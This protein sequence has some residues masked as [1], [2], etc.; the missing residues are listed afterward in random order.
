M[1]HYY[2]WVRDKPDPRD[3]DHTPTDKE[4]AVYLPQ[5]FSL[6]SLMPAVYD[7]GE[8]GSCTA[9]AIGGAVQYQQLKQ[10]LAEGRHVPSRLFI[11]W[12]E[13]YLEGTV[14]EDAGAA[15][16]DGMKVVGA[17]GV[18][19]E[20]DWPYDIS[21]FTEKPPAKAFEDALQYESKYGRVTQSQPS[22]QASIYHRRP[23]VFGFTVY[24]SFETVAVAETGIMPMPK[25]GEQILGGHAVVAIGWKL[26]NDQLYFECRNSWSVE[27]GDK[28][29]FWMPAA[30]IT[31]P[32]VANDFWHID[33]ET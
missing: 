32:S 31:N 12:N 1:T 6:R 25:K 11:Y 22:L 3:H 21:K 14:N 9:N 26:I 29:Y 5:K 18:P 20:S 7:Q 4:L 27:W 23:V 2:G 24:E 17:D 13:R 28:G 33:L 8:L 19:P 15:I 16:R 10:D 30:Y